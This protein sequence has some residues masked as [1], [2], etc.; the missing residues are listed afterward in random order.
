MEE[1]ELFECAACGAEL[2]ERRRAAHEQSWCPVLAQHA[3]ADDGSES[4]D[5]GAQEGAD[6][7]DNADAPCAAECAAWGCAP[8]V[9]S[10]PQRRWLNAFFLA[11]FVLP[12]LC[13]SAMTLAE[14]L[15]PTVRVVAPGDVDTVQR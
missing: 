14:F 8:V 7:E 4:E 15:D 2:P 1:E 13:A 10:T 12:G 5:A 6:S 9:E 3:G 11:L